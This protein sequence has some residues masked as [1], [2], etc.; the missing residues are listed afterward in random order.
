[1]HRPVISCPSIVLTVAIFLL[2]FV[3][4]D[5][6]Q[7]FLTNAS[8]TSLSILILCGSGLL[9]AG[10]IIQKLREHRSSDAPEPRRRCLWWSVP[11][12]SEPAPPLTLSEGQAWRSFDYRRVFRKVPFYALGILLIGFG[13]ALTLEVIEE[14][15]HLVIF[16]SLGWLLMRDLGHNV[17]HAGIVVVALCGYVAACDEIVQWQHPTRVGDPRD[18]IF[19]IVGGALGCALRWSLSPKKNPNATS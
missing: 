17:R 11:S 12:R 18:V 6:L 15:V 2:V 9:C 10:A 7:W 13:Y 19:G 4:R 3:A 14:R 5:L 16:G 1:M 8:R